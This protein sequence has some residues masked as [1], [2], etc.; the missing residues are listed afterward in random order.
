MVAD[1]IGREIKV[2]DYVEFHTLVYQVLETYPRGA[3]EVKL[4]LV[5]KSKTTK[6]K[7][8][9]AKHCSLLPTDAVT[10]WLLKG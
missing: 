2:G 9:Y 3:A 8:T 10:F 1:V 7:R 4:M 6:S 5:K